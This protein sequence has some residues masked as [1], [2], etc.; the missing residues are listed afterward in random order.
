MQ[1][2]VGGQRLT[3]AVEAALDELVQAGGAGARSRAG[4]L[5]SPADVLRTGTCIPPPLDQLPFLLDTRTLHVRLPEKG[6]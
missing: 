3:E 4:A 1:T 5:Q 6:T 2:C